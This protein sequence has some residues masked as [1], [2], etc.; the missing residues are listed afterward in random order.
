MTSKE[1]VKLAL[2]RQKPDRV[3]IFADFVPEVKEKLYS[4]FNINNY[5]DILV[6]LGN[7]MLIGYAGIG[8]SYY[9]KGDKYVC[10][11]GC[12]WQ[13][14]ENDTGRYTEI[15]KHPLADDKNGDKLSAYKIPD[16]NCEEVFAPTKELIKNYG[17][18]KF[19]CAAITSSIFEAGWYLH[20]FEDTL[21]DMSLR[22]DYANMLFNKVM[23]FP[24]KAG[25]KLLDEDID[26]LW[27]GDDVGMQQGMLMS[28]HMWRKFLK[29]RLYT[30]V[31][32]YKAK[33]PDVLVAYHSC[34]NIEPIIED[35]I[36][37]GIDVLNP[38]QPLAMDPALLKVKY[39]D[40]LSF[41]GGI[42]V[43]ET[44]P[45]GTPSQIREEVALRIKTLGKN[46][47]YLLGPAHN[48]QGD[49]SLENVFAL[50]KA[51]LEFGG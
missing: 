6:K 23:E 5:Y 29:P 28:K 25:L 21:A 26:M 27:L 35:L 43:Q 19:I 20:G 40:R 49:T 3:P 42:C 32:T 13:Y 45:K 47:G 9:G 44:L 11:W 37:I 41:W 38:I 50:Y 36:E 18:T 48:V 15:C 31:K 22:P 1:R 16:P 30:L 34:G 14:F 12:T 33:K 24:L 2:S 51:A 7:D 10:K 8:T 39:G 46:G 17:K 4:Y